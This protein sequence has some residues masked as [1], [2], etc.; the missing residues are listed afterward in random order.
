MSVASR[1]APPAK[2]RITV[3]LPADLMTASQEA[4]QMG[5][6]K[7]PSEFIEEAVRRY[8]RQVREEKLRR[9]ARE[10]MADPDFVADMRETADA[11]RFADSL[12]DENL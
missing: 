3:R 6:A 2:Q 12:P 9:L 7:N 1:P 4:V 8:S 5:L 10:A 11:F